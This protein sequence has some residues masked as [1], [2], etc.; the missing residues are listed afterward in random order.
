MH[1]PDGTSRQAD[2]A[3]AAATTNPSQNISCS[4]HQLARPEPQQDT[5]TYQP[6]SPPTS[7]GLPQGRGKGN[8]FLLNNFLLHLAL[9]RSHTSRRYYGK[10]S[11]APGLMRGGA[12]GLGP[13]HNPLG[14]CG[15][16]QSL[17]PEG[18][19]DLG[20]FTTPLGAVEARNLYGQKQRHC[21]Q[22]ALL[23]RRMQREEAGSG[24]IQ[25]GKGASGFRSLGNRTSGL[26]SDQDWAA[27]LQLGGC[28]QAKQP[29]QDTVFLNITAK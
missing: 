20:P 18:H 9:Q 22:C 25:E 13:V 5:T 12:L 14:C 27:Q 1:Q 23:G 6:S 2:P 4:E 16:T 17:R 29:K 24:S 10:A 19:W 28:G 21:H 3:Q 7:Q 15:G 8:N 11:T 26:H